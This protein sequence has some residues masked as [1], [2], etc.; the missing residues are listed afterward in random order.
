MMRSHHPVISHIHPLFNLFADSMPF[1]NR[2]STGVIAFV[3][4]SFLAILATAGDA[5]PGVR[6]MTPRALDADSPRYERIAAAPENRAHFI[7]RS[8]HLIAFAR[9]NPASSE[10]P[11]APVGGV[12][13]W[14]ATPI[15]AEALHIFDLEG[16]DLDAALRDRVLR[17]GSPRQTTTIVRLNAQAAAGIVVPVFL[18]PGANALRYFELSLDQPG[19]PITVMISG[20]DGL[21]VRITTSAGTRV[22]AVHVQ[23]YYPSVILGIDP[24]L[25]TQQYHGCKSVQTSDVAITAVRASEQQY[26]LAGMKGYQMAIG[27]PQSVRREAPFL[28]S[29]SDPEMPL[30]HSYGIAV[31]NHLDYV[32]STVLSGGRIPNAHGSPYEVLRPFRMPEGLNGGHTVVLVVSESKLTPSGNLGHSSVVQPIR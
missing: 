10:Q 28:G 7:A 31:L 6:I 32:R 23:T 25:V 21:A 4:G 3:L 5:S 15:T 24:A 9:A 20:Y 1:L 30:P 8:K 29:F 19:E 14:P 13:F 26:S 12:K 16:N 18:I 2:F 11:H 17:C 27:S 22:G